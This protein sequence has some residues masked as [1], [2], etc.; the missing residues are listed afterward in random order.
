MVVL[1][2]LCS[3]HQGSDWNLGSRRW[4]ISTNPFPPRFYGAWNGGACTLATCHNH[5]IPGE[6]SNW[7]QSSHALYTSRISLRNSQHKQNCAVR[8]AFTL[9]EVFVGIGSR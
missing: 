2:H 7:L 6:F 5:I 3:R 1:L 4:R 8:P 9:G